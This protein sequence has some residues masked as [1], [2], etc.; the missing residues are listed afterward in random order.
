[1]RGLSGEKEPERHGREGPR[2]GIR[3]TTS[4]RRRQSPRRERVRLG[5]FDGIDGRGGSIVRELLAEVTARLERAATALARDDGLTETLRDLDRPATARAGRIAPGKLSLVL[6]ELQL[7]LDALGQPV[8]AQAAQKALRTAL[9]L[10]PRRLLRMSPRAIGRD[11][12]LERD[13]DDLFS[14]RLPSGFG[15]LLAI[16]TAIA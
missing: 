3:A 15:D 11:A 1:M 12:E 2:P 7:A 4:R 8:A 10:T 6:D 9:R 13:I 5:S 16:A 14:G